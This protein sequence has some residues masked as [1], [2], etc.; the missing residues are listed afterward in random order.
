MEFTKFD[1][2]FD[3]DMDKENHRYQL[4]ELDEETH[5]AVTMDN[6]DFNGYWQIIIS[7]K[8]VKLIDINMYPISKWLFDGLEQSCHWWITNTA[9]Y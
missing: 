3:W 1:I 7:D 6:K 4:T 5:L 8:D 9:E 2:C